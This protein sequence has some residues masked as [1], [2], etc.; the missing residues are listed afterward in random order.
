VGGEA[1]YVVILDSTN[2]VVAIATVC[3]NPTTFCE[4]GQLPGDWKATTVAAEPNFIAYVTDEANKPNL[5]DTIA[6]SPSPAVAP[7]GFGFTK[8]NTNNTSIQGGV[9]NGILTG[10]D[11]ATAFTL[12]F[13]VVSSSCAIP[14]TP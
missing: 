2:T 6:L 14:V 12:N 9:P 11:P 8:P 3:V 13:G 4:L 5:G 1:G 10:I 7:T